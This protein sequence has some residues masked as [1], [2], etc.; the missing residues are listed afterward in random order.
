MYSTVE[1][2]HQFPATVTEW[3]NKGQALAFFGNIAW[4]ADQYAPFCDDNNL[5]EGSDD[6]YWEWAEHDLHALY[7]FDTL[8][9]LIEWARRYAS[10]PRSGGTGGHQSARILAQAEAFR[11][12]AMNV[13]SLPP[14]ILRDDGTLDTV[15]SCAACGE[16]LRYAEADRDEHGAVEEGW[17]QG[18]Q[19]E[20]AEE[21]D[22]SEASSMR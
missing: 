10:D 3:D 8:E 11:D 19:E 20:H 5:E 15:L 1:I 4:S 16:L 21:C 22:G 14:L 7:R 2:P 6:S 13:D 12:S 17:M 9:E 18:I